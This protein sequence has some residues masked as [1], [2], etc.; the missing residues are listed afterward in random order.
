MAEIKWKEHSGKW[1]SI[2]PGRKIKQE[3]VYFNA[4]HASSS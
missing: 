1:G 4:L 2:L 3:C